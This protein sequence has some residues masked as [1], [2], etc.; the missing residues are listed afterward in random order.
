MNQDTAVFDEAPRELRDFFDLLESETSLLNHSDPRPGIR[1]FHLNSELI[2]QG[3]VGWE[4]GGGV[5]HQ[6]RAFL[7]HYR[8][9]PGT[10]CPPPEAEQSPRP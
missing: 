3:L 8:E 5:F 2:M 9:A 7:R 1:R 10:G 4:P 6:Y